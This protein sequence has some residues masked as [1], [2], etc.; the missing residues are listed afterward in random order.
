MI[1]KLINKGLKK[2]SN[3]IFLN[4]YFLYDKMY[5]KITG[6]DS[7]GVNLSWIECEKVKEVYHIYTFQDFIDRIISGIYLIIDE[8]E[9]IHE[10]SIPSL[11]QSFKNR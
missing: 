11:L 4:K 5:Y 7:T 1:F 9:D 6:I 8:N 2:D 3:S 10:L